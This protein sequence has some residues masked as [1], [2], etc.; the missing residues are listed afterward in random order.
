[1]PEVDA[2]IGT[3]QINDILNVCDPATNTRWLPVIPIGNQTATYLYDE[4]TP[5]VL[6]TPGH[7]AFVKI[8]EGCDRPVRVLF[9]SADARPLSQ[10]SFWLNR[11]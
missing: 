6:A 10:P 7:Y 1:M 9:H 11:G 4:S 5:R 3:N 2:F 8:A